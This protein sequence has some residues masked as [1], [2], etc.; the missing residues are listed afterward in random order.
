MCLSPPASFMVASSNATH[1]T[2]DHRHAA[3][4]ENDAYPSNL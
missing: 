3:R 2:C 4:E 1:L